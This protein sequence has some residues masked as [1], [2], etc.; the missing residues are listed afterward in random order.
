MRET[1][2]GKVNQFRNR[3]RERPN[4]GDAQS[5]VQTNPVAGLSISDH[6]SWHTRA[7]SGGK[8]VSGA[9][10]YRRPAEPARQNPGMVIRHPLKRRAIHLLRMHSDATTWT[11]SGRERFTRIPASPLRH[12]T[13]QLDTQSGSAGGHR[14]GLRAGISIQRDPNL[15]H[16]DAKAPPKNL[17]P[18]IH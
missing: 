3:S 5:R 13:D 9:R 16:T 8:V 10:H 17:K 18:P 11:T 6:G 4:T 14:Y 2:S 15:R 7:V 12:P 1:S